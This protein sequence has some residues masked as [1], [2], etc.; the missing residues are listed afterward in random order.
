MVIFTEE[1]L[2]GKLHF[3]CSVRQRKPLKLV[4]NLILAGPLLGSYD[5]W[6][7]TTFI[8]RTKVRPQG[9]SLHLRNLSPISRSYKVNVKSCFKWWLVIKNKDIV[10]QYSWKCRR[11][12]VEWIFWIYFSLLWLVRRKCPYSELF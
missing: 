3:L 11:R 10:K 4:F 8:L 9:P 6:S 12:G 1:I 5:T 2:N 7:E